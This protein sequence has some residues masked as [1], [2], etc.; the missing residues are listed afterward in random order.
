MINTSFKTHQQKSAYDSPWSLIDRIRLLLWYFCWTLF[1][2]WTP[3][4][5]N[6]WR[7][8]WL[9]LF[10]CK[11]Y[12][13]PF[14]HQ[15]SRIQIPWNLILHDRACLGDRTN[16]YSLGVIEIK[17]GATIAQEAYLCT[18]T[19]DFS[20]PNLPLVTAKITINEDAFIGARAF[21]MPG[22]NIGSGAV[23]GACSV[24]TKD[25]PERTICAGHPCRPLRE[26]C[27]VE[28]GNK[29]NIL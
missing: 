10:S 4:P 19:H 13:R 27:S 29:L 1:C 16:A 9:R 11:I 18:G 21:V 2:S 20:N 24:V 28:V 12:G 14:V 8:F 6:F 23:I 7:L 3:K 26:R 5:L 25:M 22:V 17:A 15:S